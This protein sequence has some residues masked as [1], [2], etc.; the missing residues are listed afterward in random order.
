LGLSSYKLKAKEGLALINGTQMMTAYAVENIWKAQRLMKLADLAG[1]LSNEAL[2]GSVKAY[3][4]EVQK[5]RP[6]QGQMTTA[7]NLLYL[8][9][10]SE[11]NLSH[12]DCN[13]VQD[14]YSL[15]CIPQVHGAVRDTLEFVKKVI[16]TEIN[17]VTDNPLIFPEN[18]DFISAGN[19]HGEP[20]A[21]V[22]DY[23]K[24]AVSELGNIS[25]RR[26]ARLVDGNLSGLPRFLTDKGGL[27]S[28]LMIAQYTAAAL[29]SEN[30]LL[31][32]PASTD[33]IPTSANQE[34]H[35][36]M[37]SIAARKC[38]EVINNAEKIIA[39]EILCACQGIDFLRPLKPGKGTRIAYNFVRKRIKHLN[40][41][42]YLSDLIH[43][44][45]D[46]VYSDEL[47]NLLVLK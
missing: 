4:R 9:E 18:E 41:D 28:G 38:F 5:L 47:L 40:R 36:S 12:E 8:L 25:E 19:F 10:E 2:R 14:S 6:H 1:A 16:E 30:K 45:I 11:I 37:G 32:H 20:A 27:N 7:E 13:E 43:E 44:T 21:L 29:V 39:I 33:S 35:N 34:D 24:I 22:M 46:T 15:R 31:S 23:L 3:S 26:T 42:I 17:S